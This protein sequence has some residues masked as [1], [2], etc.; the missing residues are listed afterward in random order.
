M[1]AGAYKIILDRGKERLVAIEF[2]LDSDGKLLSAK[3][4]IKPYKKKVVIR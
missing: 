3:G 4:C 2:E 1:K